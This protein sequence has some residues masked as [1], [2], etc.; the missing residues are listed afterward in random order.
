MGPFPSPAKDQLPHRLR[1]DVGGRR[2]LPLLTP[3]CRVKA[4][5]TRL[6]LVPLFLFLSLESCRCGLDS[7]S[8]DGVSAV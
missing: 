5:I 2:R 4:L 3:S 8:G 6:D 1:Y 7:S